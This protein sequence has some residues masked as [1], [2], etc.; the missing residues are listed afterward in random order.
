[1]SVRSATDNAKL[2]DSNLLEN[3]VSFAA[4][5]DAYAALDKGRDWFPLYFLFGHSIELALKAFILSTGSSEGELRK[6]G[7][8]LV[9]ALT[10]AES[11]GLDVSSLLTDEERS[12]LTLLSKW[13]V[14]QV[15]RYPLLQGYLIPRPLVLRRLLEKIITATY[16]E[17]WDRGIFE[18]DR[19]EGRIGLSFD[20]MVYSATGT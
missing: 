6:I 13:H 19:S 1:M 2:L 3:A 8:N 5:A 15:T 7:H 18:H 11:A 16:V 17:I 9:K 20:P 12:S 4:A 14:Q 10:G